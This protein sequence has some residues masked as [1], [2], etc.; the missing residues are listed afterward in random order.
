MSDPAPPEPT[1]PRRLWNWLNEWLSHASNR[2]ELAIVQ[3]AM[4]VSLIAC[5]I[6]V[7]LDRKLPPVAFLVVDELIYFGIFSFITNVAM[8]I[9][10]YRRRGRHSDRYKATTGLLLIASASLVYTGLEG[11]YERSSYLLASPSIPYS[12]KTLITFI[13][14]VK[15]L[16]AFGFAAIG[17]GIFSGIVSRER[18]GTPPA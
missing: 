16:F 7:E 5:G 4:T 8:L 17:A 15:H 14:P 9:L 11:D 3:W 1:V 10:L 13:V 12:L 6:W 18:S 2:K